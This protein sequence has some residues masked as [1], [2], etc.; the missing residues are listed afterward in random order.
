MKAIKDGT[1]LLW[2]FLLSG[3]TI[4]CATPTRQVPQFPVPEYY[5][6]LGDI[7]ASRDMNEKAVREY[8][9]ALE[10][11]PSYKIAQANLGKL[12]REQGKL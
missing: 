5:T 12:Y 8:K 7:Y 1:L 3:L 2:G 11:N 4:G 9:R 6:T 10:I